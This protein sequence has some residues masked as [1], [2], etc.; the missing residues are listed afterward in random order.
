MK[1]INSLPGLLGTK[2]KQSEIL[3]RAPGLV[4]KRTQTGDSLAIGSGGGTRSNPLG[5]SPIASGIDFGRFPKTANKPTAGTDWGALINQ[6]T[7][8]GIASLLSG[9]L[10]LTGMG[11]VVSTVENLFG[12]QKTLPTLTP[13]ALAPSQDTTITVSAGKIAVSTQMIQDQ[14][15]QIAQAVKTAILNSNSLNDIISE[16]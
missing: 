11:S 14:S 8:D 7:N 13:F 6:A 16:I 2:K 4:N 1:N 5:V 10:N 9:G 15:A 12:H 3:S